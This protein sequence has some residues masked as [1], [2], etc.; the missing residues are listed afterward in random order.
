MDVELLPEDEL[1]RRLHAIRGLPEH[2]VVRS[3]FREFVE[4]LYVMARMFTE[5]GT[6]PRPLPAQQVTVL[7]VRQLGKLYADGNIGM[8]RVLSLFFNAILAAVI[9][10]EAALREAVVYYKDLASSG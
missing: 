4:D 2:D 5:R 3:F 10:D 7:F 1:L 8:A 9:K 6:P